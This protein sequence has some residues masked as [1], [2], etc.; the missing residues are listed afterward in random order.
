MLL[1]DPII[2]MVQEELEAYRRDQR[3]VHLVHAA[4]ALSEALA[5]TTPMSEQTAGDDECVPA[6]TGRQ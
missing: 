6:S 5:Q 4:R 3:P 1:T 2:D